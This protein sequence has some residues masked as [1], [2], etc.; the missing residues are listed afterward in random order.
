MLG[1]YRLIER[2]GEGGIGEVWKAHDDNLDRG[3]SP[4]SC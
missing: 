2:I 3:P 1:R 4:A